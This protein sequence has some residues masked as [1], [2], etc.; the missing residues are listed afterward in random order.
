MAFTKDD[1]STSP[2]PAHMCCD[3]CTKLCNCLCVC[4]NTCNCELK[5]S[6]KNNSIIQYIVNSNVSELNDS[7]ESSV[8][9]SSESEFE[10]YLAKQPT[11]LQFSDESDSD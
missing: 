8:G 4:I 7:E 10:E 6:F 3:N 2:N 1:D 9:F 5:C 11:V